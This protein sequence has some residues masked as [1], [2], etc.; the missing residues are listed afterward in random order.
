MSLQ[1]HMSPAKTTEEWQSARF[2][3]PACLIQSKL[4]QIV[5]TAAPARDRITLDITAASLM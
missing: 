3:R 5:Q 4:R 2:G 1:T